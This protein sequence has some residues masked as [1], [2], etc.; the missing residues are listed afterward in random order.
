MSSVICGVYMIR[1]EIEAAFKEQLSLQITRW[2]PIG[3]SDTFKAMDEQNRC[4][5]VKGNPAHSELIQAELFNLATIHSVL[6]LVGPAKKL[7]A[8]SLVLSDDYFFVAEFIETK[9]PTAEEW[10]RAGEGLAEFHLASLELN[11]KQKFGFAQDNYCGFGIQPNSFKE[12]GW[13]FFR[14]QRLM[15]QAGLAIENNLLLQEDFDKI[16]KLADQLEQLI[17]DQPAALLHGDLWSGNILFNREGI[18]KVIDPACYFG[19]PEADIAMTMLFGGFDYEFYLGYQNIRPLEPGW[20]DRVG[21]YNLFHLLNHLN[22]FG[23][24]Y[25]GQLMATADRY[26]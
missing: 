2:H 10:F 16:E 13:D 12:N 20:E 8:P 24:S 18:V 22:I 14:E 7:T 23:G 11:S 19:W 26:L 3:A 15:Y 21:L 4:Y 5:F 6:D 1:S 25:H 9:A 17:P